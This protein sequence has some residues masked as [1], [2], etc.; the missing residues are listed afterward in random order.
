MDWQKSIKN[1]F[2]PALH[3]RYLLRVVVVAVCAF[4]FFRF[5]LTPAFIDGS[6][7]EPTYHDR[8]INGCW[9][10]RFWFREPRPGDVVMIRYAGRQMLFKRVVAVAGETV[11][12]R[13]GKLYVDGQLRPEPWVKFACNWNRG[14]VAVAPGRFYVIGDNRSMPAEE[15]KFGAVE[16]ELILG[17]PLW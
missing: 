5:I 1:F 10:P 17:G 11:E 7:M 8:G 16:K 3:R 9:H 6:S 12:F 2:F 15:H 14:P 13:A 4:V